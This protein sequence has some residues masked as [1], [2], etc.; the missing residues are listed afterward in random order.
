M[1][2]EELKKQIAGLLTIFHPKRI[3]WEPLEFDKSKHALNNAL[4]L[5]ASWKNHGFFVDA[6][7]LLGLVRDGKFIPHDTDIDIAVIADKKS[8]VNFVA[9]EIEL[10]RSVYLNDLPM[11]IA[12]LD[13]GILVDFYFYYPSL[14]G[15]HLINVNAECILKLPSDLLL[16]IQESWIDL[17]GIVPTPYKVSEYLEWTYGVDWKVPKTKKSKWVNDRHN[18]GTLD[19]LKDSILSQSEYRLMLNSD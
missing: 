8:L 15:E 12:Y 7:T 10:A 16:P 1:Q 17:I 4:K 5:V 13:Q 9:P 2:N 18:F 11:Q 3:D 19:D 14:S 6:G